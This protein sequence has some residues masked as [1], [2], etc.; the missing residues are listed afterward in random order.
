MAR[1]SPLFVLPLAVCLGGC[2]PPTGE[3]ELPGLDEPCTNRCEDL[4][5][6][7]LYC[8]PTGNGD[9][10]ICKEVGVLGEH[11]GPC[12]ED[13][14]CNGPRTFCTRGEHCLNCPNG[15]PTCQSTSG[16]ETR[17]GAPGGLCGVAGPC[18]DEG[19]I[20]HPDDNVCV[21]DESPADAGVVDAG[22]ADAGALDGGSPTD[23][24]G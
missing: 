20:C 3:R 9:E 11:L 5:A 8:R 24:G 21:E 1:V 2:P 4:G 15:A 7:G 18:R 14:S 19:F 23:A 17:V 16:G 22:Q 10:A 6:N 12:L 13:G